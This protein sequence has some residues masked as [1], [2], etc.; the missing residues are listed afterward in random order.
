MSGL[1]VLGQLLLYALGIAVAVLL[2]RVVFFRMVKNCNAIDRIA[3]L[4]VTVGC[5]MIS[6]AFW[7]REG[8]EM[9]ALSSTEQGTNLLYGSILSQAL[10]YT[11]M[12]V[13][14]LATAVA[15]AN[16]LFRLSL[17]YSWL[18]RVEQVMDR[19]TVLGIVML[20]LLLLGFFGNFVV[21]LASSFNLQDMSTSAPDMTLT[22]NQV[23]MLLLGLFGLIA[24][25]RLRCDVGWIERVVML[26]SGG[27]AIL[28][29]TGTSN[30]QR[31]PLLS[32]DMQQIAGSIF[33]GLTVLPI[34]A[35]CMLATALL[36]LLW[37]M[38]SKVVLDR[39]VLGVAFGSAAL[40]G[41]VQYV[42]LQHALLLVGL[43]LLMQGTL[44]GVQ[45]ER[46]RR[47]N[48]PY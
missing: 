25:L 29:L 3:V 18:K 34:V 9:A 47:G 42:S 22:Y 2:L 41:L 6:W 16:S 43:I 33:S 36:S 19:V 40:C 15:A 12:I 24:L 8:A 13:V 38:R 48:T 44:I 11:L 1:A 30:V 32:M 20:I 4:I 35:I 7:Q 21:F 39:V 45:I 26:L 27:T 37:L 28:M 17:Q 14:V 46:V 5:G 23:L 10:G 31:L